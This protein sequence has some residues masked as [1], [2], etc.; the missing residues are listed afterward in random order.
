MCP[1]SVL[2]EPMIAVRVKCIAFK[3]VID[4]ISTDLSRDRISTIT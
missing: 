2:W 4:C 1:L 3:A